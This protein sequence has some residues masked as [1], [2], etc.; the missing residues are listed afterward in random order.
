M[1]YHARQYISL[2]SHR[3]RFKMLGE[4]NKKKNIICNK[5]SKYNVHNKPP[6]QEVIWAAE[7][8]GEA[9]LKGGVVACR[10]LGCP[11]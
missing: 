1:M 6:D 7:A 3:N 5:M 10:F 9:V 4:L 11:R 2:L 8:V